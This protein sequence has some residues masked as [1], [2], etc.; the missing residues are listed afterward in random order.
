MQHFGLTIGAQDDPFVSNMIDIKVL[1]LLAGGVIY[2]LNKNG[3]C[4]SRL[5]DDLIV[6]HSHIELIAYYTSEAMNINH[7]LHAISLEQFKGHV[8]WLL[9]FKA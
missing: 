1:L 3:L 2:I 9:P 6:E 8:A 5:L 7:C 4:Q